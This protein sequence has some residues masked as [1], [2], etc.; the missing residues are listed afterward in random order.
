MGL[1][2]GSEDREAFLQ[3]WVK[4][5]WRPVAGPTPIPEDALT[6]TVTWLERS[7][8]RFLRQVVLDLDGFRSR[9][10]NRDEKVLEAADVVLRTF[11]EELCG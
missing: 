3:A 2:Q 1:L 11:R 5:H 6:N 9:D 8:K 10:A 7:R 4:K